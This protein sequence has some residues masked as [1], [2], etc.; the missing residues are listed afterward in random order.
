MSSTVVA[1]IR[2]IATM[3]NSARVVRDGNDV[4]FVNSIAV[5][6]EEVLA[7]IQARGLDKPPFI[8]VDNASSA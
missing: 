2:A 6:R 8:P 7:D 4:A 5:E 3:F 1:P